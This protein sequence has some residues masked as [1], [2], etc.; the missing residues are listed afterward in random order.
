[1]DAIYAS[2]WHHPGV[3]W[4]SSLLLLVV[5]LRVA[6]RYLKLYVAF[7]LVINAL[8]AWLTGSL[9]PS[10]ATEYAKAIGIVFVILGDLRYFYLLERFTR[11]Q[12]LF[13]G[14]VRTAVALALI[15]PLWQTAIMRAWP[16]PFENAR[17]IFL[18]YEALFVLV[19][20]LLWQARYAP[21]MAGLD[22]E[23]AIFLQQLTAFELVQYVLWASCDALLLAGAEWAIG[24]RLLPNVLYYGAFLWFVVS[25]APK[26]IA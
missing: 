26:V 2:A 16:Q 7:W 9:A 23:L 5:G 4:A 14:I 12:A 6:P 20:V 18:S 15:V 21:K 1:M 11:R 22:P 24:L 3:A 17:I 10:F 25:K 19:C 13:F 8:D